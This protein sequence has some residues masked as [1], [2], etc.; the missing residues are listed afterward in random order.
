MIFN[1]YLK[2]RINKLRIIYGYE[3][4]RFLFYGTINTIFSNIIL[5]LFLLISSIAF[6]TFLSQFTN[7]LIG[8]FLYSK[9]VFNIKNFS[10]NQLYL[11]CLLAIIS[12]KLNFILIIFLKNKIDISRN[13]AA[14]IILPI[15]AIWSY[16]IQ[17][18]F[19]F[20]KN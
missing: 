18:I 17:K 9:K 5:H 20:K 1:N 10:K 2:K 7:L 11:Y 8:F 6:A 13:L 3:K 15:L 14:I 16:F 12:W 4:F 19:I